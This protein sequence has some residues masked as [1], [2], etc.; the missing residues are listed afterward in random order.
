VTTADAEEGLFEHGS[1][2]RRLVAG[3]PA[4]VEAQDLGAAHRGSVLVDTA[5]LRSAS[6]LEEAVTGMP[7][8]VVVWSGMSVDERWRRMPLL[9]LRP[10]VLGT[11]TSG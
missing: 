5:R 11:V 3:V 4:D 6:V 7:S 9:R 10:L 8:L 1:P 2:R